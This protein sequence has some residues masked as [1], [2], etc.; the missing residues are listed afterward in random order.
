[1]SG[2]AYQVSLLHFQEAR[3]ALGRI[4][5]EVDKAAR[6]NVARAAFYLQR[7][8][9]L[10]VTGGTV[11]GALTPVRSHGVKTARGKL[12]QSFHADTFKDTSGWVGRVASGMV[13][14]RILDLGGEV[15]PVNVRFLTL[16]LTPEAGKR[17][18]REFQDLFVVDDPDHGKFLARENPTDPDAPPEYLYQ[19]LDRVEIPARHYTDKAMRKA[20]PGVNKLLDGILD[21]GTEDFGNG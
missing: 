4:P 15:R 13:S 20:L 21:L 3:E 10:E 7:A 9:V 5:A 8:V 11:G 14:A 16:P 12:G 18:A 2:P 1:M 19:L 6:G 17:G